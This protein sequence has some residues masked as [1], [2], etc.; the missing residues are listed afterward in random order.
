MTADKDN[1]DME[2]DSSKFPLGRKSDYF[3]NKRK[4][5]AAIF[6]C[7]S[8]AS[9]N[10]CQNALALIPM[11]GSLWSPE[12]DVQEL[13]FTFIRQI[14]SAE[15]VLMDVTWNKYKN[16]EKISAFLSALSCS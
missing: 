3:Q 11:Y 13:F 9:A 2:E 16:T 14:C 15:T 7:V 5:W 6:R 4:H 12:V 8:Y 10:L 1:A